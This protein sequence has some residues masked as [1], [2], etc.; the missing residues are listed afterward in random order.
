MRAQASVEFISVI[1]LFLLL[2]AIAFGLY[3]SK[4]SDLALLKNYSEAS[5]ICDVVADSF[6]N[7][8]VSG[9]G[10]SSSV[11]LPATLSNGIG[12]EI[13]VFGNSSLVQVRYGE[14]I[15]S[16]RITAPSVYS[17]SENFTANYSFTV[18]NQGGVV[19]VS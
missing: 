7:A 3:F 15:V 13:L 14:R 11:D 4:Q 6:S 18:S 2:L 9:D 17:G 12:Y 10:Y 8:F 19:I 5:S 1:G 16:C